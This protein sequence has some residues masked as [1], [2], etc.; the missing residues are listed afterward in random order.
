M[1]L[2]PSPRAALKAALAILVLHTVIALGVWK[3]W[4]EFGRG[5]VI[6]WIDFPT[7][8]AYLHLDGTPML[9]WSLAAGGL[10]WAAIAWLLTLSLGWATRA[11]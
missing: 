4:G 8:L 9:L 5:N 1:T 11:R 10:Q 6:A 2:R 7:S 3:T